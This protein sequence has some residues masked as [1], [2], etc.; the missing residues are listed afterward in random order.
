MLD[1]HIHIEHQPYS[2]ELIDNMVKV[3]LSRNVDEINILD[4]THKF[5]EFE[6]LYEP[7]KED[8]VSYIWYKNHKT[9]SISEYLDFIKLV[10]SKVYPIKINFGLEVCYFEKTED[11]LRE[12]LKKYDFDFLIGSVH[13]IDGF[14]FDIKKEY[15][16]GRDV[17]Y[18]YKRY[19]EI[20]ESLIKSKLFAQVGHPDAI[21]IFDFTPTFDLHPY[22]K[23]IAKTMKEYNIMTE[24]NSGFLR[25]G[26][27][28]WGL[29]K[30]FFEILKINGVCVNKSSDAHKYEDIGNKFDELESCNN[31]WH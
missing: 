19:F 7:T 31:F 22:Y 30:D 11:K 2:L 21:K 1:S 13:F 5:R 29:N 23:K 10:K 16:E 26:F 4:H 3:A 9:I 28:N 18:L 25:Y 8:P 17:D 20:T 14:A 12:E 6:F 24:N 27:T 15:W